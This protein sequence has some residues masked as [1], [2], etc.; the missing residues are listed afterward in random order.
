MTV[1]NDPYYY[2]DPDWVDPDEE[3]D[4]VKIYLAGPMTGLPE[5]NFPAFLEAADK[6]RSAGHEVMSPAEHDLQGGFDPTGDGHDFNLRVAFRWD[7]DQVQS[8]DAIVVLPGWTRSKGARAEIAVAD[9][10]G[11]PIYDLAE[12][13]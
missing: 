5:W 1:T 11:T 9:V 12:L 13:I 4:G 7:L 6:L 8:V 3:E 10:I 2:D